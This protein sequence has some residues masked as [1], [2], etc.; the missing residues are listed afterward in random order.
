MNYKQL[1]AADRGAIEVLLQ[2]KYTTPQIAKAIGYHK[3]TVSRELKRYSTPNGYFAWSAQLRHDKCRR[4]CKPKRK[5]QSSKLQKYIVARLQLGWSPE[6]IAGRL[7]YKCGY[8]VICHETIYSWLY[9]DE[10]AYTQEGLYQYLRYGRDK[11]KPHNGRSVHRSKIPNRVSI[12]QRPEVVSYQV[13]YGHWET[14]SVVYPYKLAINTLNELTSGRVKFT[15]L[16]AKTAQLTAQAVS[17]QLKNEIVLSVTMDNSSEFTDHQQIIISTGTQTYFADPYSSWQRGANENCNMLLR[18]YLPKRHDIS[19]LTQQELDEIAEE[20]NNRPRK[21][22]GFLT[23]NEVY[24]LQ[25][26]KG[27]NV[28]V[29]ARM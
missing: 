2:Q 11:R 28:A 9:Q 27:A 16:Q 23:P 17:D 20:L 4:K 3:S 19:N 18:G 29:S 21:R 26:Q 24:K 5:L 13:E 25:L 14:D 1:T 8:T 7:K 22:L 15:K 10:W 12:H 6:Q